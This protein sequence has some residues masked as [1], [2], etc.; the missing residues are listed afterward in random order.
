[1]VQTPDRADV[2]NIMDQVIASLDRADLVVADL[3]GSS[4]NVF[5]EL[6]IRHSIGRAYVTVKE[7]TGDPDEDRTPFDIAAYRYAVVDVGDVESSMKALKPI[8]EAAHTAIENDEDIRNPVTD[9]YTAPLT[10][11]ATAEGLALG[12]YRN[13]VRP[14]TLRI[15]G[16]QL[17]ITIDG[18]NID[19]NE[20]KDV[21]LEIVIPNKLVQ[22]NL[23][24]INDYLLDEGLLIQATIKSEP[25]DFTGYARPNL[26]QECRLVDIP[27]PISALEEPIRRRLGQRNL[28]LDSQ[29]RRLIEKDQIQRFRAKLE[30]LLIND[31]RTVIQ[32][33][34]KVKDWGFPDFS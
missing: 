5:Y 25:C 27:T 19:E 21:T 11:I 12:Y 23:D 13:F 17:L 3:T 16:H 30:R 18:K 4:P 29:D 24:N 34:V 20:R 14:A 22:A 31:E 2:G 1:M 28:D 26:P 9:F 7:E 10:Q 15:R 8:I 32:K 33:V 6:A